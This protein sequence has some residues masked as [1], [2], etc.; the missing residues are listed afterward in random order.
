VGR[1]FAWLGSAWARALAALGA[2]AATVHGAGL[3]SSPWSARVCFAGRGPGEVS[4]GG[5]EGRKVVGLAQR[6]T[7]EAALFH[8]ACLL[9]W[10]PAALVALL[11]LPDD[12]ARREAVTDLEMVA[13][14]LG[15]GRRP[16]E[17][18]AALLAALL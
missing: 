6:R 10:D 18:E 8:C 7:R 17:V 9:A 3:V 13:A 1:A 4:L 15:P 14:G 16:V 12:G 2:G 11:A 5:G